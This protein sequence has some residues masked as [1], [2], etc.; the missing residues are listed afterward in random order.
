MTNNKY[1]TKEDIKAWAYFLIQN[2]D[3]LE[4]QN[5]SDLMYTAISTY[6][7][8]KDQIVLMFAVNSSKLEGDLYLTF[9]RSR[10]NEIKEMPNDQ[11]FFTKSM[12]F[13][14]IPNLMNQ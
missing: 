1:F 11:A 8:N 6:D 13:G 5:L 14:F 4:D 3:Q 12:G 9:S 10:I 7:P 2:V